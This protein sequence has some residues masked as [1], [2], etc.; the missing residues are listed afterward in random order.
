[1]SFF[2][3]QYYMKFN[4]K[5]KVKFLRVKTLL[6]CFPVCQTEFIMLKYHF[7]FVFSFVLY[8]VL[9]HFIQDKFYIKSK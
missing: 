7:N 2:F 5:V 1:M 6:Q 4:S 9:L 8:N 3:I